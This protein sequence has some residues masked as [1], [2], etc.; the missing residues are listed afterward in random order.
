MKIVS[1]IL[2]TA[3][4]LLL[5]AELMPGITVSGL[6]P[7]LI[8]AVLLGVLNVFIRPILVILTLPI[9]I[10]TLG[11]FTFVINAILFWFVASFVT[12]FEVDSFL[13]AFIGSL[14]VSI[15]SAIGNKLIN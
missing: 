12:G 4:A 11:L 6:Y 1:R 5:V 10:I 3:L 14:I 13:S 15:V 7:A 8:S 9:T 2:L